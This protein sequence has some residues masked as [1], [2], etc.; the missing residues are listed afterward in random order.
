MGTNYIDILTMG[1]MGILVIILVIITI[2]VKQKRQNGEF[3]DE[4]EK[5]DDYNHF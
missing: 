3:I 1:G 4:V 5:V 2:V